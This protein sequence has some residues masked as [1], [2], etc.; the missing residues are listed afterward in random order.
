MAQ[1]QYQ[2][3]RG[4]RFRTVPNVSGCHGKDRRPSLASETHVDEG[5]TCVGLATSWSHPQLLTLP[6]EVE[7]E[8]DAIAAVDDYAL[9]SGL[10]EVRA[11]PATRPVSPAPP[12]CHRR[13]PS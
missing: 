9:R 11:D 6:L 7:P 13:L 5:Q 2:L 1:S 3:N 12:R 10:T 4:Q 8:M